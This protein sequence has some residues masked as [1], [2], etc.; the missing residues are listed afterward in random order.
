MRAVRKKSMGT[1]ARLA[2]APILLVVFSLALCPL[3]FADDVE[4]R[5]TDVNGVAITDGYTGDAE[6]LQQGLELTFKAWEYTGN[7]VYEQNKPVGLYEPYGPLYSVYFGSLSVTCLD[8]GSVVIDPGSGWP[9]AAGAA[10]F[11]SGTYYEPMWFGRMFY[12]NQG[13]FVGGRTYLVEMIF[14]RENDKHYGFNATPVVVQTVSF[15][16]GTD[17]CEHDETEVQG[18]YDAT[19]TADGYTGDVV[20]L[21]CGEVVQTGEV[22]SALGHDAE[23]VV[24]REATESEDG[25]EQLVCKR[26]GEVL[27]ER[28]IPKTG[29]DSAGTAGGPKSGDNAGGSG[30]GGAGESSDSHD[31]KARAGVG[32]KGDSDT[33]NGSGPAASRNRSAEKASNDAVKADAVSDGGEPRHEGDAESA[34]D[35]EAKGDVLSARGKVYR[36]GVSGGGGGED[37]RESAAP[38]FAAIDFTVTGFPVLWVLAWSALPFSFAAGLGLKLMR[39]VVG[40]R[41]A[42]RLMS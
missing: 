42:S 9:I 13:V 31:Q 17:P 5:L 8:D 37:A 39:N 34:D 15:T 32:Q 20:C 25:L 22:I 19:C 26:D 36:V 16:V 41:R 2:I 40:V 12:P 4:Y 1:M 11:Y 10:F 33:K 18:A 21:D 28:T 23:W 7:E 24:V 29:A 30:D 14:A 3:A 35:V 6:T 38:A 27:D